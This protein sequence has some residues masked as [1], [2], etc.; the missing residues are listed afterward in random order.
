MSCNYASE[1]ASRKQLR[2]VAVRYASWF[3]NSFRA[4]HICMNAPISSFFIL[5]LRHSAVNTPFYIESLHDHVL[6]LDF[7]VS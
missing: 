4:I 3:T 1:D 2:C 6:S 5:E 7:T